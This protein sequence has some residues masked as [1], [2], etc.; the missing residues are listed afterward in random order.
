MDPKHSQQPPKLAE[1]ILKRI[2][3]DN[4]DFTHLGDF[5]EIHSQLIRTR[6]RLSAWTWYL[7]QVCRSIPGFLKNKIYWSVAMFRNYLVISI[8]N[9]IRN[10]WFSVI[11]IAGLSVGMAAFLLILF[12]VQFE[13][14][15][16]RFHEKADRIHIFLTRDI[17]NR[18]DMI[19]YFAGSPEPLAA[20]LIN[21]IPE[22]VN[23]TRIMKP[24]TPKAVLQYGEKRFFEQGIYA[25]HNFFAV[26]TFPLIKGDPQKALVEPNTIVISGKVA[27]KLFGKEDPM[28]K[29]IVYRERASTYELKVS[30]VAEPVPANSHLQPDY[31]ISVETLVQDT[32]KK[33]MINVWNVGNFTTFVELA[34]HVSPAVVEKKILAQTARRTGA[35]PEDLKNF[36]VSLQPI[37][38]IHLRSRIRD[39]ESSKMEIR[40]I[41]LFMSIA[42]VIL[43]IACINYMN[44]TTARSAT[45]AREIGIRKVVGANRKQLFK[46]FVG[47][48]CFITLISMGI[49]LLLIHVLL[50]WFRSLIGVDLPIHSFQSISFLIS[51][52]ATWLFISLFAGSYPALV[53]SAT[54]PIVAFREFV[55]SGKKESAFRNLLVI[56]QFTASVVL[57]VGT[58]VIF[59]QMNHVKNRRLGYDREHVIVIL[60]HEKET[61]LKAQAIKNELLQYPEVLGVTVSGALPLDV[62]SRFINQQFEG[63]D[64][65]TVRMDIRFDYVDYD[66]L[67]V[68]KIEMAQGR[69]FSRDFSEDESSVIVN[70]T[71]V[72]QLGWTKPIGKKLPGR[73]EYHVIGVVKDFYFASLHQ[74]IEPMMFLLGEGARIAVRI[75]PGNVQNRIALLKR[76]FESNTQT[77]PF[78]Y[79]FLD[80][81]FNQIYQKD[82]RTGEIFGYFSLL[83]IFIACL[84]LLG[85]ASYT[86]ERRTKE[87]GIRRVLGASAYR[88]VA[89]LGKE[90]VRL[91]II[92]NIIAWPVAFFAMKKWLQNFAYRIDL[93]VWMFILAAAAALVIAFVTVSYQTFKAALANPADTLRYE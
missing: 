25:D 24:W 39:Q 73:D 85:L 37:K 51:V 63:K 49:A 90:Y 87:I 45:R 58:I 38:D 6:G 23:A 62:R 18:K 88:I 33:W 28:G 30:G 86:V 72:K 70:E 4:G 77:Q 12:Y 53:L 19:E 82:Q 52:G 89:L 67:D 10:T 1:W 80:D 27:Q 76:V 32:S 65:Q 79:F 48:S 16:E 35:K 14:S 15:F 9:I 22:V 92:A 7:F 60:T 11:K 68:F 93:S 2:H 50:P 26:F 66:F 34:D 84:G 83:A 74:K 21:D 43:L 59:R 29:T 40:Y 71:A 31:F 3:R 64:G 42:L 78:D 55:T 36:E 69:N 46:Q 75:M 13:L 44:L 61:G 47:E 41:Y 20:A 8:R 91:V 57:I 56:V 54:K 5:R 81:R 17:E